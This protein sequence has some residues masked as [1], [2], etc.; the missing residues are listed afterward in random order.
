[1]PG[2]AELSLFSGKT[3]FF[4]PETFVCVRQRGQTDQAEEREREDARVEG[5][6]LSRPI[7]DD[8]AVVP[9]EPGGWSIKH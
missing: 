4:V 7:L 2:R 1:M 5:W 3:A 9:P 8:T 6:A